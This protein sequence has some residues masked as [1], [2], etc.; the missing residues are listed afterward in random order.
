[1]NT[2]SLGFR[3][4]GWYAIVLTAV[5]TFVGAGIYLELG[6]YLET[7]L[8]D[9]LGRRADQVGRML[10]AAP[11]PLDE[12]AIANEIRSNLLPEPN[13]R[14]VH[15]T[16]P[17]GT[18]LYQSGL[19]ADRSFDPEAVDAAE[20]EQPSPPRTDTREITTS[21]GVSMLV[22][23]RSVAMPNGTYTIEVGNS[24]EQIRL[25]SDYVLILLIVAVPVLIGVS[26]GGGYLL[27][28]RALKSVERIARSA[29]RIT[30]HNLSERLPI[31]HTGDELEALAMSVN[32]MIARLDDAFQSS[33]RFLADVS[34]ELRTPLT[35]IKGELQ[36][37]VRRRNLSEEL[38]E[39]T[40]STLEEVE[41]LTHIVEGLLA[42][43]RLDTG[44]GQR[45]WLRFDLAEL[46]TT[47]ADQMKLLAEDQSVTLICDTGH[48]VE[49][50]GDRA[51]LKQVIVNLLDNA[52]KYTSEGGSIRLRVRAQDR[53]VLEVSDTGIGIPSD[54]LAR[55]FDRFFRV[56]KARSKNVEGTGLGLAIVKSICTA[57]GAEIEAESTLGSGSCFRVKLPLAAASDAA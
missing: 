14:F 29:E 21:Q 16:R 12:A 3:L 38:R 44:E 7:N 48:P 41:R 40:G 13:N 54:E 26:A 10:L 34:H 39:R 11:S 52:I 5:F 24:L 28:K 45:E 23:S 43:A 15:V 56:D 18:L 25:V 42:V 19:P 8:R 35:V 22:V 30:H 9:A 46:A 53:A 32:R 37:L 1:M 36:D 57:H 6:R 17:D 2:R 31:V 4:I 20:R 33:R 47:T 51:R 49:V 50:E 27:I 55:V